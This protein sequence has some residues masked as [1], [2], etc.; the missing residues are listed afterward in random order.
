MRISDHQKITIAMERLATIHR[1]FNMLMLLGALLI[2]VMGHAQL[3]I[4]GQIRPRAEFRDGWRTL[5][6]NTTTAAFF[7][8]QRTRLNLQYA[9]ARVTTRIA[10]QDVRIWGDQTQ[11]INVP[12]VGLHEAWAEINLGQNFKVRAGRQ[13]WVYDDHR[14]L[15]NVDWIQPARSHDGLLLKFEQN[16]FK[17]H[18]GGAFNQTAENLFSTAYYLNNYKVLT[19]LRAE[20]KFGENLNVSAIALADGF[21]AADTAQTNFRE[22]VGATVIYKKKPIFIRGFGYYQMGKDPAY[23][24]IAAYMASLEASYALNSFT[25]GLGYDRISGNDGLNWDGKNHAFN[26]LYATNHKF[27][28]FMDYFLDIPGN[29]AGGGLQDLYLNLKYAQEGK[30]WTFH[31]DAHLFAL[32]GKV[33]DPLYPTRAI[34]SVL[35]EEFD[36]YA[37]YQLEKWLKFDGGFSFMLPSASMEVLKGGNRTLLPMWGWLMMDVKPQLLFWDGGKEK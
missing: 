12:R 19:F 21:T 17:A 4:T 3:E 10:L 35:G 28:G 14:L 7:V 15:G 33:A 22:T 8:S 16:G 23:A 1:K 18:L 5:R 13:E 6:T 11:L 30:K 27:Y 36:L 24:S 20:K 37:G 2:P 32:A 29:T 26:T 25:I 9:N 34:N 31:A